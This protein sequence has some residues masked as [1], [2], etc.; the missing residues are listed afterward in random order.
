MGIARGSVNQLTDE[1]V[2]IDVALSKTRYVPRHLRL[3]SVKAELK[4]RAKPRGT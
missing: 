4:E 1:H 2:D 3:L